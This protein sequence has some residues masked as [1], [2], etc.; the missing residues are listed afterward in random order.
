MSNVTRRMDTVT[1]PTLLRRPRLRRG[2]SLTVAL[3]YVLVPI[4]AHPSTH[5]PVG[6]DTCTPSNPAVGPPTRDGHAMAYDAARREARLAV[7]LD[8]YEA[9]F[10][11]ISFR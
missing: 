10:F 1:W 7:T 6:S 4:P 9:R 5:L 11:R 3:G 2:I 8:P